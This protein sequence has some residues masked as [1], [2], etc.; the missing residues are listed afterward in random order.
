M[1]NPANIPAD[2][3]VEAW[4]ADLSQNLTGEVG[5]IEPNGEPDPAKYIIQPG[6]QANAV[7]NQSRDGQVQALMAS[8]PEATFWN[9]A[10]MPGWQKWKPTYRIGVIDSIDSAE[11]TCSLTLDVVNSRETP[12]RLLN[13]NQGTSLSGVPIEYMT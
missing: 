5:T 1:R 13:I 6:Y 4:C 2:T 7:Y 9:K 12:K 11:H 10:M 3:T 8:T